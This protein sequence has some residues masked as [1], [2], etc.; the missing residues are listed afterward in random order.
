MK[1]DAGGVGSLDVN[2]YD[3]VTGLTMEDGGCV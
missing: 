2:G 3:D 1:S